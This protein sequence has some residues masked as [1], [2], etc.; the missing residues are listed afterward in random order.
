[1]ISR[2]KG[3]A[4]SEKTADILGLKVGDTVQMKKGDQIV[5]VEI[6]EIVGKLCAAFYLYNDGHISDLVRGSGRV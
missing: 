3:A 2:R 4:I 5:E 1:M 6:T